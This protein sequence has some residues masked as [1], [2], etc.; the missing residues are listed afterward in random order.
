MDAQRATHFLHGRYTEPEL[1]A[2]IPQPE[3]HELLE[4][5][6]CQEHSLRVPPQ[7]IL[8]GLAARKDQRSTN[9][10]LH[11]DRARTQLLFA[12]MSRPILV[13]R[14]DIRADIIKGKKSG[15][16]LLERTVLPRGYVTYPLGLTVLF[17]SDYSC[18]LDRS[19][20]ICTLDRSSPLPLDRSIPIRLAC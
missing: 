10:A 18:T 8:L 2:C 9:R 12:Q 4:V 7:H 1:L 15:S 20:P 19:I 16:L 14:A 6:L 3:M 13:R 5:A 17:L 11:F